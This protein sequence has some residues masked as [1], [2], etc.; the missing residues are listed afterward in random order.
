MVWMTGRPYLRVWIPLSLLAVV[1]LVMGLWHGPEAYRQWKHDRFVARARE[2][3]ANSDVRAA[4][5]HLRKAILS[6]PD[7]VESARLMA[8][9]AEENRSPQIVGWRERIAELEPG[10]TSN[11]LA[12]AGAA[13]QFGDLAAADK[14]LDR[15]ADDGGTNVQFQIAAAMLAAAQKNEADVLRHLEAA[16]KLSPEDDT[17]RFKLAVVRLGSTNAALR[18]EGRREVEGFLDHH[19]LRLPA[20]RQLTTLALA[21]NDQSE[22]LRWSAVMARQTNAVFGDQLLRLQALHNAQSAEEAPQLVR[23]SDLARTQADSAIEL[24]RWF[25]ARRQPTKALDWM[26]SLDPA[27]RTNLPGALVTVDAL[28]GAER[29][30][31]VPSFLGEQNWG[32]FESMR[33]ALTAHAWWK[34]NQSQAFKGAWSRALREATTSREGLIRLAQMT[35]AWQWPAETEAV[36][37]E[38]VTRHPAEKWA[39]KNLTTLLYVSGKTRALKTLLEKLAAAEPDNLAVRNNLAM[40][41]LLLNPD[42]PTAHRLARECYEGD[43]KNPNY[44]STHAFALSLAGRS[45]EALRIFGELSETERSDTIQVYLGLVLARAGRNTEATA[46]LQNWEKARLLPEEVA[47]VRQT[48]ATL[49]KKDA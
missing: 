42:D 34:L 37:W 22:A 24:G 12:W 41:G 26:N 21:A 10:V 31:E 46:Q 8:R 28:A 25:I 39:F 9:L 32:G 48:L 19:Q 18:V 33:H 3:L 2:A 23:V 7:N 4:T 43:P 27:I 17:L 11:Y 47:L 1:A 14:A 16:A 44:V 30:T 40:T 36:L 38:I 29:W 20:L 45:D 13:L 15:A 49:P 5:L 35:A 6:Q